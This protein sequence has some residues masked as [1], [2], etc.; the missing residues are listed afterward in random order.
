MYHLVLMAWQDTLGCCG[1]DKLVPGTWMCLYHAQSSSP[2]VPAGRR[3]YTCQQTDLRSDCLPRCPATSDWCLF[4]PCAN[5]P[6]SPFFFFERQLL[7]TISAPRAK[8]RPCGHVC[9]HFGS[10]LFSLLDVSFSFLRPS[11]S[12]A[13]YHP[14]RAREKPRAL[15]AY[16]PALLRLAPSRA[17]DLA[18]E[19]IPMVP[20]D[21]ASDP[22]LANTLRL[23]L[24]WTFPRNVSILGTPSLVFA[25]S[26]LS[27][28]LSETRVG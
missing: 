2:A 8:H 3:S 14:C 25:L 10:T 9:D 1:C 18:G 19:P 24:T 20:R 12:L 13:R 22:D 4:D 5:S 26:P 23:L 6:S 27:P 17:S 28:L 21:P 7:C 16:P 15:L 11:L